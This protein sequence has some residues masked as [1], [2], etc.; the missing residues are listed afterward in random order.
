MRSKIENTKQNKREHKKYESKYNDNVVDKIL[1]LLSIGDYTIDD[2]AESVGITANTY[3]N[4][5]KSNP[6]FAQKIKEAKQKRIDNIRVVATRS[7][8][9]MIEGYTVEESRIVYVGKKDKGKVKEEIVTT[10]YIAPMPAIV[11]FALSNTDPANWRNAMFV[12]KEKDRYTDMPDEELDK[13]IASYKKD[14]EKK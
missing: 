11:I 4:W 7:L 9:R 10:K 2:I 3:Y 8:V 1:N 12:G 13:V 6:E 5:K 14:L